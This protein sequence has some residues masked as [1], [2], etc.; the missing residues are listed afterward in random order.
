MYMW[1]LKKEIN[2]LK[3]KKKPETDSVTENKPMVVTEAGAEG[4]GMKEK[5]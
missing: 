1:N 2:K 3:K 4:N 5:L